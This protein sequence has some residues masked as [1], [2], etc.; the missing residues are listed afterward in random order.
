M[1]IKNPRQP[2]YKAFDYMPFGVFFVPFHLK[3]VQ[4]VGFQISAFLP[5]MAK[6]NVTNTA[7]SQY[8]PRLFLKFYWNTSNRCLIRRYGNFR[9]ISSSVFELS[10]KSGMGQNLPTSPSRARARV[11]LPPG[12]QK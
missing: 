11:G 10:R 8:S 1:N 4:S 3:T 9:V 2:F 5:K 12:Q 6:H 7:F